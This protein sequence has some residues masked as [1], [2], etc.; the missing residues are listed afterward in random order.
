M[1]C[2]DNASPKPLLKNHLLNCLTFKEITLQPNND[3]L[4]LFCTVGFHLHGN[5]NVEQETSRSFNLFIAR[6]VGLNPPQFQAVHMEDFIV[7]EE[8]LRLK[9]FLYEK[10]I[11]AAKLISELAQWCEQKNEKTIELLSYIFQINY[12][13]NINA[14]FQAFRCPNYDIFSPENPSWN[15]IWP[16]VVQN[17]KYV[18]PKNVYQ[19]QKLFLT[20]WTALELNTRTS[21]HY[22]WICLYKILSPVVC[23][24]GFYRHWY[25]K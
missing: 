16:S 1:S 13:R 18:Y 23:K 9:D 19:I 17:V 25:N 11:V 7:V 24:S 15:Y 22:W 8:L 4:C 12:V 3:N 10:K 5:Q 20:T 2:K 21:R 14:M 6:M